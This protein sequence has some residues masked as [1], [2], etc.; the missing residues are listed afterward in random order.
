MNDY[1]MEA[2]QNL[3]SLIGAIESGNAYALS[4]ELSEN[5]PF[6]E[7]CR[8]REKELIVRFVVKDGGYCGRQVSRSFE[9]VSWVTNESDQFELALKDIENYFG[10]YNCKCSGE[11]RKDCDNG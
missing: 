6:D 7:R 5:L 1:D 10:A 8:E 4:V 11:I 2:V 3:K 9:K